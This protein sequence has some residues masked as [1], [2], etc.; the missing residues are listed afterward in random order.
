[1]STPQGK[2]DAARKH[3]LRLIHNGLFVLTARTNDAV[4]AAT[5]SWVSQCSF[6]PPLVMVGLRRGS[7]VHECLRAGGAAVLH[8]IGRGQ[9]DIARRFFSTTTLED[10]RLNGEPFVENDDGVP[11][12]TSLTN[13]IECRVRAFHESGGDHDLVVLD[14]VRVSRGQDI[15]PLTVADS[16]WEYGG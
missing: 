7:N 10:G 4:G 11:L 5:V 2:D 15:A 12:V 3:V 14:V 13:R 8:V 6:K 16:P 9:E 1:M